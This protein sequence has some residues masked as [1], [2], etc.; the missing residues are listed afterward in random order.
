MGEE[1][2]SWVT[3][4]SR[5]GGGTEITWGDEI[6]TGQAPDDPAGL[7][8]SGNTEPVSADEGMITGPVV[9]AAPE[10][11]APSKN[12]QAGS[13]VKPPE[14]DGHKEASW[15]L[16]SESADGLRHVGMIF[17]RSNQSDLD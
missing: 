3:D 1:H 14:T 6:Q 16:P 5:I 9:G 15:V 10:K 11:K 7:D 12:R 8:P 2:D 4:L 17:F 13:K